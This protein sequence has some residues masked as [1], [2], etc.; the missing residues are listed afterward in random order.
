MIE[1]IIFVM[2]PIFETHCLKIPFSF[3]NWVLGYQILDK[4]SSLQ[5]IF[6]DCAYEG[7]SLTYLKT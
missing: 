4:N 7:T 5:T 2:V 3:L 6:E 1:L